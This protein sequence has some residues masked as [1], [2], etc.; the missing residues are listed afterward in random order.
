MWPASKLLSRQTINISQR[1]FPFRLKYRQDVTSEH[2]YAAEAHAVA[3]QLVPGDHS[4]TNSWNTA[5]GNIASL[6][7]TMRLR[8]SIP[9]QVQ[10]GSGSREMHETRRER[11]HADQCKPDA[12]GRYS[13]MPS[14]RASD[15]H[16]QH[17]QYRYVLRPHQTR[18][19]GCLRRERRYQIDS[20]S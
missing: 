13:P 4:G 17:D 11:H 15:W 18:E 19:S 12:S 9:C 10:Q 16:L 1:S 6:G 2:P 5:E 20:G 14:P 8:S 3:T 7:N